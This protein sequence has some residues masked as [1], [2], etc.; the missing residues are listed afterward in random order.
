MEKT[1]LGAFGDNVTAIIIT[2]I[3]LELKAPNEITVAAWREVAPGIVIYILSFVVIAIIWV[4]H[5]HLFQTVKTVDGRIIWANINLLFWI[6]LIPFV[7]AYMGEHS[8]KPF[9][10]AL[11]GAVLTVCA[12]AFTF[13][14]SVIAR[15]QLDN[16]DLT[17]Q[18]KQVFRKN[19]V[20]NALVE[21]TG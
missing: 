3:I 19:L 20:S 1:R 4:N 12:G 17:R 5:H 14:R 11:Y 16:P 18:H 8:T 15:Y 9:A 7:I 2:I 13:L 10:V 21:T 6:S